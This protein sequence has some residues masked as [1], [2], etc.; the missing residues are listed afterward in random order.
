MHTPSPLLASI[1]PLFHS[2]TQ[3]S[4]I[5]EHIYQMEEVVKKFAPQQVW[6]H[7]N[8]LAAWEK[9]LPLIR[10]TDCFTNDCFSIFLISPFSEEINI[11]SFF[12][13]M[14][15]R[16]I[17]PENEM[18]ILSFQ[19]LAFSFPGHREKRFFVAEAKI[20]V[21]EE[22][23]L[24]LLKQKLPQ[25]AKEVALGLSSSKYARY[26]L[27]TVG[28]SRCQKIDLVYEDLSKVWNRNLKQ[29]DRSLL[30][31]MQHFFALTGDD[32][33]EHRSSR[34]LS[35]L[36]GS[37]YLI[38]KKLRREVTVFGERR[39][40]H[41]R[42]IQT[43]LRFPFGSKSV[44]GLIIG[45]CLFDKQDIFEE[46][47]IM[48]AVQ[49]FLPHVQS[50]KGSFYL[51]QNPHD[52]I[53]SL[54]LELEKKQRAKFSLAEIA[55][56]KKMLPSELKTRVERYAPSLFMVR[57]EEEVMKNILIL[58]REL[59]T[60]NDPPQMIINLEQQSKGHLIFTITL[61]RI[62]KHDSVSIEKHL[63]RED[64]IQLVVE[65]S[66]T[67]GYLEDKYPKE[68]NV[69]RLHIPI[70]PSFLRSDFSVNF[71]LVRQKVVSYLTEAFKSIRDFNGGLI[72]KQGEL[73]SQLQEA[74][75]DICSRNS[76]LLENFF[77]ALSPIERQTILPLATIAQFF[78]LFHQATNESLLKKDTYFMKIEEDSRN[79]F[80]IIRGGDFS[81]KKSIQE[82]ISGCAM[83]G[84]P[85]SMSMNFQDT[86]ILGYIYS[87]TD[88][89]EKDLLLDAVHE[90]IKR[91]NLQMDK[92]QVLR[93]AAGRHPV[94]FDPRI[95]G[96]EH[97]R[98]AL[99]MLF[100]GL[101]QTGPDGRPT[102][103]IAKS[104][105]ISSDHKQYLFQLRDSFWSN[106]S[107]LV[108]YDFEYAWKK[109]L[110]PHFNTKFASLFYPI[111]NAKKARS[112]L[113]SLDSVGIKALDD[114]TLQVD[115][116]HPT[117]YFLDLVSLPL[118]SPVSHEIDQI[119]P[120]WA[121]QDGDAY[122][123]NGPFHLKKQSVAYGCEFIKN[124]F[125]WNVSTISLD[126][127][128]IVKTDGPNAYEMFKNDEIDWVGRSFLDW[129]P[130]LAKQCKE[131]I[132]S[133][134]SP[135]I[136]WCV[137]NTQ[138]FPFH[139]A[140]IRRAFAHAIDRNKIIALL[141]SPALPATTPLPYQ[142]SLSANSGG[143]QW[144]LKFAKTLFK[145]GLQEL[146]IQLH[147]LPTFTFL[148]ANMP[149]PQKIARIVIQEWEN[150]L[151]IKCTVASY[152]WTE[153]FLKLCTG[154]YHIGLL[155]WTDWLNDPIYTSNA[156]KYRSEKVNFSKWEN[157]DY[158]TLLDRADQ[159]MD[160][161][162][163][164][165]LLGE[166][167]DILIRQMPVC[168]LFFEKY[169]YLKKSH[170]QIHIDPKTGYPDFRSSKI[171]QKKN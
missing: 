149:G 154:E 129:D 110:S 10:W 165:Q 138:Q 86:F 140:K 58:S 11:K 68:A 70:Q 5:K 24:F 135:K 103:A 104:F 57:N 64:N 163:R 16:C 9:T 125:Y 28:G 151:G 20:F 42:L 2:S 105:S 61:V 71:Y 134:M 130:E 49:K 94:S 59:N 65:R 62:L 15:K 132:E 96:D 41:F 76:D 106:G 156:F 88:L 143:I 116:E 162:L 13:E 139:S 39:H 107:K 78:Q 19:H 85:T 34:H 77:Y 142:L 81:L 36:I 74:F 55:L 63:K 53:R 46:K 141:E 38:R 82:V 60:L 84:I 161:H 27:E 126:Q 171:L 169:E 56:L 99:K 40:L 50:V 150:N 45:I 8:Y 89:G 18:D 160:P 128:V 6:E 31:E 152:D 114:H 48:Q 75:S 87:W 159:E 117:P 47:H 90:G 120:N 164:I 91:W 131:Q 52:G 144:D 25:F 168:P 95:G 43:Q 93:L 44:L 23:Q 26:I 115:L 122:V 170:L 148:S 98:I 29:E 146:G 111:K 51:Y 109:I 123:C 30:K 147:E 136:S 3:S 22:G 127:I 79:I 158:Q 72:L 119:H 32:F 133:H 153:L 21:E 166:A 112:S 101:M 1:R 37:N 108:A 157:I 124:P 118:F 14:V 121:L 97:S 66:Q 92:R 137:F 100:E 4:M 73:L 17:A 113:A 35:R 83:A 67:V 80:I 54:Y 12:Q 155:T 33:K 7:K 167:E 145:E 102:F 69:F